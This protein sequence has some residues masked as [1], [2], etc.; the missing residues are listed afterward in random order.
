MLDTLRAR[1]LNLSEIG[2][3]YVVYWT[4]A[5]VLLGMALAP[6]VLPQR[7]ALVAGAVETQIVDEAHRHHAMMAHRNLEVVP[8][9]APEVAIAITKD[10]MTGWNLRLETQNFTFAPEAIN[11]P[12]ALN[13]GHA[14]VYVNG[15]KLGRLY[16]HH[17]HLPDFLPG[18]HEIRVT[19]NAND[20]STFAVEGQP[21]A[22]TAQIV[23]P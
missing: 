17:Y 14:H 16:G 6:L 15:E 22:A 5:A 2:L 10:A 9:G 11:G 13:Q 19:L 1:T 7:P 4:V 23:Q 12:V 20:H 21:I 8:E 18:P 3:A